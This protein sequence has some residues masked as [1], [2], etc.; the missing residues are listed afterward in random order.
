MRQFDH[1]QTADMSNPDTPITSTDSQG[2]NALRQPSTQPSS[3]ISDSAEM[4]VETKI[5]ENAAKVE[6]MEGV[7]DT[8][9]MD[10]KAKALMHLLNTSEVRIAGLGDGTG[11][12]YSKKGQNR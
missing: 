9:G 8:E 12:N 4:Q 1:P 11:G 7:D 3:P 6:D 5:E 2:D 10:V